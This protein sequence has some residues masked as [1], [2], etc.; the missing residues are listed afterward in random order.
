M[1]TNSRNR[2]VWADVIRVM[3]IFAVIIQHYCP[4]Y[5]HSSAADR[6]TA[7]IMVS[8]TDWCVPVFIM[9]SGMFLL[10]PNRQWNTRLF[11]KKNVLR[12]FCAL[13]FWS[14][15][16]GL[17]S[18]VTG[19]S[20]GT[21]FS[22]VGPIFWK[23]LPWYHLWFVYLILGLYMLTPVLRSYIAH[24]SQRNIEYLLILCFLMSI[25]D[26]WNSFLPT[27]NFS[28]PQLSG[29][30]GYYI[31]GYYLTI[32]SWSKKIRRIVYIASI[33]CCALLVI[34][35]A[36]FELEPHSL[37]GY[38]SPLVAVMSTGIVV[39]S[40]NNLNHLKNPKF[41]TFLSGL[42]F[43]I[44]LVHDLFI[45]IL[46]HEHFCSISSVEILIRALVTF[47]LSFVVVF[48]IS[49]IPVAKKYLI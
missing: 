6:L 39:F 13:C 26:L 25:I 49:K 17:F 35:N 8:C 47:I 34:L 9:L 5:Y 22:I 21:I 3:A 33:S 38:T 41:W 1:S 32:V 28:I 16:Y 31:L 27:L 43:G 19:G 48:C 2:V 44:Y 11:F 4:A 10:N 36:V 46:P 20:K 42:V 14:V 29:F 40:Q 18:F 15:V 24:A 37:L 30:I 23:R 45:Q 7:N 12:I